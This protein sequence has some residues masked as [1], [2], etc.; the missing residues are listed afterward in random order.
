MSLSPPLQGVL[1][2][3]APLLAQ[4]Q[5]EADPT[6]RKVG[7]V[8][9]GALAQTAARQ[10]T[11]SLHPRLAPSTLPHSLPCLCAGDRLHHQQLVCALLLRVAAAA[12]E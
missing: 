5:S 4:I 6:E 8:K 2:E 12:A 9:G 3:L 1:S 7:C 11:S 10:T